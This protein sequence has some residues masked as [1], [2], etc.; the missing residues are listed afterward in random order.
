MCKCFYKQNDP[1]QNWH[2]PFQLHEKMGTSCVG[3]V[4]EKMEKFSNISLWLN[5]WVKRNSTLRKEVRLNRTIY[6]RLACNK[7]RGENVSH[8]F[9]KYL[10]RERMCEAVEIMTKTNQ[11]LLTV[12]FGCFCFSYNA[13]DRW[14]SYLRV[15]INLTHAI[16]QDFPIAGKCF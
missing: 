16:F 2:F 10:L 11:K 5:R 1:L 3:P 9:T 13:Q 12:Q 4:K 6:S 7:L 8:E 15:Y 14:E